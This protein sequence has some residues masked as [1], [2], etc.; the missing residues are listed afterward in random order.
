[1]AEAFAG[2]EA[3]VEELGDAFELGAMESG[4]RVDRGWFGVDA[5][6]PEVGLEVVVEWHRVSLAEG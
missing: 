6:P 1:M 5:Q 2:A 3:E 4:E